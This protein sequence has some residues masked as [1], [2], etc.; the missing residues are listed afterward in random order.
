MEAKKKYITKVQAFVDK[1]IH[2]R[3]QQWVKIYIK[4]KIIIIIQCIN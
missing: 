4:K 1:Y 2:T 3:L